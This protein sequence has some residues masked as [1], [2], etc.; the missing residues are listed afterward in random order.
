MASPLRIVDLKQTSARQLAPLFSEEEKAWLEELHWDY[1]PSIALI[2]RFIDTKSL[3]GCA[4]LSD[5]EPAGYAFYVLEDSKGLIGGLYVS[6]RF[7]QAPTAQKLLDELL[8]TLRALPGLQRIEAQLIPFG[9]PLDKAFTGENFRL[10]TRQFMLLPL[11]D[12][13]MDAAPLPPGMRMDTWDD[14]YFEPC[15]RL[16]QLAYAGHVDGEINDQYR[17]ETGAM[18]FLKNIIILPGCGQ[19]QP[20]SSFVVRSTAADNRM[21]GVVL[22]SCVSHGV[23][24]TTQI[25]VLPECRGNGLGLRLMEASVRTL[26]S[27]RFHALSLT[28][29]AQNSSAVQLYERIG[30]RTVKSFSAA[31]WQG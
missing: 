6:P 2:S 11:R 5:G 25:C 23:G 9:V 21:I 20:E 13:K 12:A 16:I 26:K 29:T 15:A 27:R 24:H 3:A 10:Y 14:R 17:S 31:V 7:P 28:V 8:A 4:V 1:R 18:K 19:F 30:F 22:N